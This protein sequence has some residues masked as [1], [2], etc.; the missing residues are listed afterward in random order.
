MNEEKRKDIF[1]N[2]YF[3]AALFFAFAALE[4]WGVSH[5]EGWKQVI[6]TLGV[7]FFIIMGLVSLFPNGMKRMGIVV[8]WL[9]IASIVIWLFI[10]LANAIGAIPFSIIA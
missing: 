6:V 7:P 3:L 1:E 5:F 9:V 8:L 4:Y 2:R 10:E